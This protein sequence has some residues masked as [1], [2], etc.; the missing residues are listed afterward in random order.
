MKKYNWLL[1]ATLLL[2]AACQTNAGGSLTWKENGVVT[3]SDSKKIQLDIQGIYDSLNYAGFN[4]M[5]GFK[6]DGEGNNYPHIARVSG[7]LS[8]VTYWPFEQIP[9]D[10]Y[11]YKALIHVTTM[12]GQ[13]YSLQDGKWNL[14]QQRFPR[15]SHVVYSDQQY[16]LVICYP[17][18]M[19]KASARSGGCQSI[20]NLWQLDFVWFSI[21]PKVCKGELYVVEENSAPKIL[22][23]ID[24]ATGK[25][26]KTTP[27]RN[28]P[29]DICTL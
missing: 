29:E 11:I 25:I 8:S 3:N 2:I 6:V 23:G 28:V 16:K 4:Y 15:E 27:L 21:V 10:I 19:E 9:N 12:N 22:K 14:T 18:S 5:A 26:L 1:V 7:D 24:L 13:V 17:A 20:N